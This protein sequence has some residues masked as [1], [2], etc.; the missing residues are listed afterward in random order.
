M[1][2]A[3]AKY[4]AVL[5]REWAVQEKAAHSMASKLI[6]RFTFSSVWKTHLSYVL[7]GGKEVKTL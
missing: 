1:S 3:T 6:S 7:V 2:G 4:K 5:D